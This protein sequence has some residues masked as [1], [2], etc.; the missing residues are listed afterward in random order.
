M[1]SAYKRASVTEMPELNGKKSESTDVTHL[2]RKQSLVPI[3][4]EMVQR[5]EAAGAYG[6]F[7]I[8]ISWRGG[9]ICGVDITDH[10]SY[11]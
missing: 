3:I 11:K 6:K 2:R 1:S 8:E 7:T 9:E 5:K 10:A 4:L